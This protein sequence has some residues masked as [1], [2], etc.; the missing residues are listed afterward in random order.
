[1]DRLQEIYDVYHANDADFTMADALEEFTAE[2]T[3]GLFSTEDGAQDF[4]RWLQ[5]ESGYTAEQKKTVLQKAAELFE[6]IINRIKALLQDGVLSSTAMDF[7]QAQADEAAKLRQVFLEVLDGMEVAEGSTEQSG[8]KF[9]I[10]PEFAE[11]ID[12]WDGKKGGFAFHVGTTS[13]VLQKLGVDERNIYWYATKIESIMYDHPEMTKEVIKQ[14]PQILENPV[15]VMESKTVEGR[16]TML[17]EVY[18]EDDRPVLAVLELNPTSRDHKTFIDRLVVVNAF[19]KGD[20]SISDAKQRN[21]KTQNIINSSN[22]LYV[23][24]NE[25]RTRNW[26]S[27]NRLQLPLPSSSYGFIGSIKPQKLQKVNTNVQVSEKDVGTSSSSDGKNSLRMAEG[28]TSPVSGEGKETAGDLGRVEYTDGPNGEVLKNGRVQV[29]RIVTFGAQNNREI[30]RRLQAQ[31]DFFKGLTTADALAQFRYAEKNGLVERGDDWLAVYHDA[32]DA[33]T[34]GEAERMDKLRLS[35]GIEA[36]NRNLLQQ[37]E[38]YRKIVRQ[39]DVEIRELQRTL[40]QAGVKIFANSGKVSR[41]AGKLLQG[42][43]S[44][45]IQGLERRKITDALEGLYNNMANE[46]GTRDTAQTQ[47]GEIAEMILSQSKYLTPEISEYSRTVINDV[48]SIGI[49]LSDAQKAEAA[50]RYGSYSAYYRQSL[51]KIK[52][53]NDGVSLDQRWQELA[54]AEIRREI[55]KV[56]SRSLIGTTPPQ[57][58]RL[59]AP[60]FAA[61]SPNCNRSFIFRPC[62]CERDML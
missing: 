45:S 17:G 37:N 31:S 34:I 19:T 41:L 28:S 40:T 25:R 56:K 35:L 30:V 20:G 18:G 29:A 12:A 27:V 53:R 22:I 32:N 26:L 14:V 42:Y 1:M 58:L 15:I 50:Y 8:E 21:Q 54:V 11:G 49:R 2:A 62:F 23:D 4:T 48:K 39:Q 7:A 24:P 33:E 57:F 3:A 59:F 6:K 46:G 44:Q 10:N 43:G 13:E 51:G 47:A 9:S 60:T 55:C 36:Q 16:L 61:P 38:E 52:I 5:N